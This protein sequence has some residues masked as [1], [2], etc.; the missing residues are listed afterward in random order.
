MPNVLLFQLDA[1]N[2][3]LFVTSIITTESPSRP[4]FDRVF[5]GEPFTINTSNL[6]EVRFSLVEFTETG[7][8][9]KRKYWKGSCKLTH[10]HMNKAPATQ[11][12]IANEPKSQPMRSSRLAGTSKWKHGDLELGGDHDDRLH[13]PQCL[14]KSVIAGGDGNKGISNA[15]RTYRLDMSQTSMG[16]TRGSRRRQ[17]IL[18]GNCCAWDHLV[19]V[20]LRD[21]RV[22]HRSTSDHET[23]CNALYRTEVDGFPAKEGV[24]HV[25]E[26]GDEDGDRD[27]VQD[28]DQ[29][30]GSAVKRHSGSH[31]TAVAVN[32]EVAEPED[33]KP[34]D[35][36]TCRDCTRHFPVLWASLS[37]VRGW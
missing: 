26:D 37:R 9:D 33:R 4:V 12:A 27:G 1:E 31:G 36:L 32:L 35:D 3:S 29:I 17:C 28:L 5:I 11:A 18:R 24:N 25:V 19:D 21:T 34:Q 14:R 15:D 2:S 16:A 8:D 20:M 13:T 6:I 30:I 7:E 23:S 10:V 22:G